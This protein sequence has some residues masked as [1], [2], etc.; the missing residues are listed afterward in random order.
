MDWLLEL[1][2]AKRTCALWGP[3][4]MGA[5]LI[6]QHRRLCLSSLC[7]NLYLKVNKKVSYRNKKSLRVFEFRDSYVFYMFY[8]M[9]ICNERP[10]YISQITVFTYSTYIY[11]YIYFTFWHMR[12]TSNSKIILYIAILHLVLVTGNMT[13]GLSIEVYNQLV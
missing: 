2:D 5:K 3:L 13:R 4:E 11:I 1:A 10:M 7:R 12:S 6:R 8:V 9:Y